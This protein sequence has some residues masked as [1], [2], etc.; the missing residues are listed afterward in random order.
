MQT[1]R[2]DTFIVEADRVLRTLF[3][4]ARSRRINPAQGLPDDL[5]DESARARSQALMRINHVGEVCAQ[6]LYQGQSLTSRNPE[7][8]AALQEAAAEE[9]DHLAWC[10][11]R[12]GELGGRKSVF[13]PFWYLGSLGMGAAAGLLGERWNL[14]FLAETERQVEAHLDTH[15]Q[16]LPVADVKSRAI[17]AQMKLDEAHHA[18]TAENRGGA[19]LPEPVKWVM[20]GASA[21]MKK[22][23]YHY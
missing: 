10:E 3:A 2:V 13:N 4:P 19:I 8:R 1:D 21:V 18:Q 22:I 12:I 16:A 15:L 23:A 9:T 14:G 6:A 7:N 17:V 20:H 11:S 5:L